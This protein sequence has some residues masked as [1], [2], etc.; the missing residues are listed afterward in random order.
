MSNCPPYTSFGIS[1]NNPKFDRPETNLSVSPLKLS[2]CPVAG[3]ALAHLLWRRKKGGHRSPDKCVEQKESEIQKEEPCGLY[4]SLW[5]W[6]QDHLQGLM[7]VEVYQGVWGWKGLKPLRKQELMRE[8][9]KRFAET[10]SSGEVINCKSLMVSVRGLGTL[11][12]TRESCMSKWEGGGETHLWW[13][14]QNGCVG[15]RMGPESGHSREREQES[16]V[17]WAG[18]TVGFGPYFQDL[19]PGWRTLVLFRMH[20]ELFPRMSVRSPA[21]LKNSDILV[22][23]EHTWRPYVSVSV[24]LGPWCPKSYYQRLNHTISGTRVVCG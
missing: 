12:P 20:W 1:Q 15:M 5:S 4:F 24:G 6:R 19:L 10:E 17:H 8:R 14:R 7:S 11:Q 23:F 21:V 16:G 2:T 3:A 22:S 13:G 9:Q 18:W